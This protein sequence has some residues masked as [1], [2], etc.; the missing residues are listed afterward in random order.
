MYEEDTSKDD[1]VVLR[2][3][4]DVG[5][6][7]DDGTKV[8]LTVNKIQEIKNGTV[9]INLKSLIGEEIEIADDGITEIDPTVQVRVTVTSE[10]TEETV[11]NQEQRK[12]VTD[13]SVPV[14]G[15][16]TITVKVFID[17]VR[18]VQES[19]NLNS[20]NPVLNID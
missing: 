2:Q 12:D 5:T 4:I 19:L 7:V 10:G 16:G 9:N 17:D 1:G 20:E 6:T 18:K 14:S 15:R 3:S 13:L 8:T 11:Y